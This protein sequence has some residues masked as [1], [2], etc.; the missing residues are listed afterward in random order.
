MKTLHREQ[1][2]AFGMEFNVQG[3]ALPASFSNGRRR[4]HGEDP[5][6]SPLEGS[7]ACH[8]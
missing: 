4:S 6:L 1:M 2:P 3:T 5:A 7:L 8:I